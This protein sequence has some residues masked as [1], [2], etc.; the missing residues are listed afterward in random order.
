[1]LVSEMQSQISL[2][3][4]L[5]NEFHN[6]ELTQKN[7]IRAWKG[8]SNLLSPEVLKSLRTAN[9]KLKTKIKKL[10]ACQKSLKA[11]IAEEVAEDKFVREW[12]KNHPKPEHEDRD[13]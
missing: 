6:V 12:I 10:A 4:L 13:E 11:M 7:L 2:N 5:L 3:K 9:K 1:M 8:D